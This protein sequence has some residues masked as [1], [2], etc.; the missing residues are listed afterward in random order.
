M[1]REICLRK[2]AEGAPCLGPHRSRTFSTSLDQK[3][4]REPE[5]WLNRSIG[6]EKERRAVYDTCSTDARVAM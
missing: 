3:E 6:E 5:S 4:K 1:G 2:G